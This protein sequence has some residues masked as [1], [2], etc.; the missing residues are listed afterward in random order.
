MNASSRH[1]SQKQAVRAGLASRNHPS[2]WR[3]AWARRLT[4]GA[5]PA[6]QR[7]LWSGGVRAPRPILQV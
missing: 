6:R 3:S 7:L 5:L 2:S 1:P 4:V